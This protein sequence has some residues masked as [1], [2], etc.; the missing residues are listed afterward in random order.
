MKKIQQR[1]RDSD[2]DENENNQVIQAIDLVIADIFDRLEFKGH[3]LIESLFDAKQ[4]VDFQK[5]FPTELLK[6]VDCYRFINK[7]NLQIELEI[8]YSRPEFFGKS[9]K[10]I[11]QIILK[12][13]LIDDFP[14]IFNL[15]A[16]MLTVP[17]ITV[18]PERKFSTLNRIKTDLRSEDR[19]NALAAI[20]VY[21]SFFKDRVVRDKIINMFS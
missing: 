7:I 6:A 11:H 21:K 18:N 14:E 15:T 8:L 2:N 20:S 17:M 12:T 4:F 3:L 16:I 1:Y 10:D 5:H 19:H 13:N 9:L